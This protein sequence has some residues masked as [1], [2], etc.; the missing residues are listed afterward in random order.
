MSDP[1]LFLNGHV[2]T[3]DRRR[4]QAAAV[5]TFGRRILALGYD[6]EFHGMISHGGWQAIDLQG[7]TLLPGFTDCH[8]HLQH[9]ASK[10]SGVS[11]REEFSLEETLSSLAAYVKQ[12]ERG[13]WVRG[14]GWSDNTWGED[15]VPSRQ[16]LDEIAP[17]HPVVLT[18]KD[19][20]VIWVNSLALREAGVSKNTPEP[21]GGILE[22]DQETGELTGILKE[23]AVPLV[24]D[25]VP[26]PGPQARQEA[27]KAAIADAHR[28]GLT[29][30]H[31][32]DGSGSLRDY[33]EMLAREELGLRVFIMIPSDNLDEAIK[34][35][36]RSG[37]GNEYLRIGNVKIFADG[38]LGS[39]T[40]EMLEPY[41]GQGENRGV[42]AITQKELEDTVLRAGEAGLACSVH[43][44]G[45]KANRRVLDA[46]EKQRRSGKG[47]SLRHRIEHAQLLTEADLPRFKELDI[48]ASMQP[49]HATQDIYIAEKYWGERTK[50]AYAWRSLL[51]TGAL[52]AFGS[53]APVE[54]MDPLA[55][56]HAAVTRQRANGEPEGGWHPEQRL[57]VG[58]AVYAYTRGAAYA[59]GSEAE[60][61]SIAPGKL[62][63]LVVLSK[64]IFEIQPEEIL[65]TRVL[66]TVFDGNIVYGEENL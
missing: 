2:Y 34:L 60:Q 62:A 51:D 16:L 43:A 17:E 9:Y 14:W 1:L 28:V 55:G 54:S 27:L 25:V 36:L 37:F 45:D 66:A 65:E 19:G 42:A 23:E 64:D 32:C 5:A 58:E 30:V 3:M 56:I 15:E 61:G 18:K 24:S 47:N 31:D 39:Q 12:A 13:V 57:S 40:G 4:P 52:V 10:A 48:I 59:C 35:G 6:E 50:L 26:V 22:R 29:G 44:L 53:D 7:K 46:F 41:T 33:Q 20:H 49:I 63:D 8:L 11:L 38:S 21:R